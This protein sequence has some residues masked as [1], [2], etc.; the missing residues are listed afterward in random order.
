MLEA[1]EHQKERGVVGEESKKAENVYRALV[2]INCEENLR[3]DTERR[4][5]HYEVQVDNENDRTVVPWYLETVYDDILI[6]IFTLPQIIVISSYD[7]S[8]ISMPLW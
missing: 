5:Y 2:I 1:R 3:E 6:P 7:K 8:G 4:G